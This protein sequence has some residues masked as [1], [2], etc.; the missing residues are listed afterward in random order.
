M[1]NVIFR[2]VFYNDGKF[3][4]LLFCGFIYMMYQ[5]QSSRHLIN[6]NIRTLRCVKQ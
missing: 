4:L 1:F 6:E 5:T 2:L 3:L